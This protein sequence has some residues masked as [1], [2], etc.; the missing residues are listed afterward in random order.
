MTYDPGC[1]RWSQSSQRK[2]LIVLLSQFS[3]LWMKTNIWLEVEPSCHVCV[4]IYRQQEMFKW[5]DAVV[6]IDVC[7]Y[8]QKVLC[9]RLTTMSHAWEAWDEAAEA[10]ASNGLNSPS[11]CGNRTRIETS[12]MTIDGSALCSSPTTTKRK[13][14]ST[15]NCS[16]DIVTDITL[17]IYICF[18]EGKNSLACAQNYLHE[19]ELTTKRNLVCKR[20]D[21][22]RQRSSDQIVRWSWIRMVF[23]RLWSIPTYAKLMNGFCKGH[24]N[25]DVTHFGGILPTSSS[26]SAMKCIRRRMAAWHHETVVLML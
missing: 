12:L 20:L 2:S 8:R 18:W 23:I 25:D 10:R 5:F 17:F 22:N 15:S 3:G 9:D 24:A 11:S 19:V 16:I 14:R 1:H 7:F 6:I 26:I 13:K 4:K 21:D